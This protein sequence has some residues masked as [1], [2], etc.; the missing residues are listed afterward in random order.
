M[1]TLDGDPV[2]VR[3]EGSTYVDLTTGL[4]YNEVL[5]SGNNYKI[6]DE[7]QKQEIIKQEEKKKAEEVGAAFESGLYELL[8]NENLLSA[9]GSESYVRLITEAL[10]LLVY[11]RK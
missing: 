2:N 11:K 4:P 8:S 5:L 9:Y 6:A 10:K 7:S 3:L 1:F